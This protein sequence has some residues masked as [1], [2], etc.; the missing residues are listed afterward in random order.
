VVNTCDREPELR[1]LLH[2]L[3]DQTYAKFEVVVVVGPTSDTTAFMIENEF[4][5][6]VVVVDCPVFNL[7]V[8]R[9]IGLTNC[10]GEIVAFID[11]DARP[12]P[13]WLE[14]I[15]SAYSEREVAGAGGR[16]YNALPGAGELQFLRGRVSVLAEQEDVLEAERLPV[17]TSTALHHWVD[18][19]HGTNMSYR[20]DVLLELGGFDERYE[21]LYDDTDIAARLRR[22][23]HELRHLDQAVVY[24]LPGSGRNRGRLPFDI[25]WY[26]WS[27]SSIY[28]A[29]KNGT[30]AVGLWRSVSSSVRIGAGFLA[31]I[32][33]RRESGEMPVTLYQ[34]ARRMI[35][36]G[37]FE[38]LAQGVFLPRRVPGRLEATPRRLRQFKGA[39]TTTDGSTVRH[40]SGAKMIETPRLSICLLSVGY[41]PSDT[42]GVSRSTHVL[43]RGLADLGH[44][45]H[46]VT[47]G[48]RHRVVLQDGVH[49]H[50]VNGALQNRYRTIAG[51]GFH[52]LA[53]WLNH[54]H[55]VFERVRSLQLNHR[56]QVVDSPLWNMDA[57]V[58]AV[59]GEIPVVVRV[60]TAMKQ[61]ADMHGRENSEFRLLGELERKFLGLASAIVSNS[62][63]TT[64]TLEEVYDVDG[65]DSRVHLVPYGIVPIDEEEL[66]RSRAAND[67]DVLVLFVG[68]LEGRKGILELFSAIPGVLEKAPSARFMIAGADNSREDGFFSRHGVD[69]RRYFEERYPGCISNVEFLGFVDED[70]LPKLY[71][72]CDI[73]VAPSLYESFGLV[74]LEA[75]N[76]ARP[77]VGCRAGGPEDIIV[78][79]ATGLLVQPGDSEALCDA[80]VRLVRSETDRNVMGKAGRDRLLEKYSHTAMAGGFVDVY[81]WLLSGVQDQVDGERRR[82]GHD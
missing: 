5:N 78:D 40:R 56:I 46:V 15:A 32:R 43:A 81:R 35:W 21:Y 75:M 33:E 30:P 41:P 39:S 28:F 23:G 6:R 11:D 49:V 36:R 55:A 79:G 67:D 70:C 22:A 52:N 26:C 19:L 69:Y 12:C 4:G 14:Q 29:I 16:T 10:S 18:R 82:E 2:S 3:E 64:A 66:D 53:H 65:N 7:S 62:N 60:V 68:R 71:R 48:R 59:S 37:L 1:E 25:N 73:F 42:H 77:V 63:G 57:L 80:L 44:E 9:N 76:F 17:K 50:E 58:T 20:R 8:S 34:K 51:A 45:V 72:D 74:F 54:S 31:R 24:H 61:I 13:T 27:R 47:S 38:G